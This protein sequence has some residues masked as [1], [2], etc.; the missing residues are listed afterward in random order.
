MKLKLILLNS[1]SYLINKINLIITDRFFQIINIYIVFLREDRIG[2]QVGNTDIEF[3]KAYKR[4]KVNKAKTIFIFPTPYFEVSNL[5]VREKLVQYAKSNNYKTFVLN[6]N[7]FNI[8]F[9]NLF[10]EFLKKSF[11][12]CK[13]IYFSNTDKG[14]RINNKILKKSKDHKFLCERMGISPNRYIC[15]TSR[16]QNYLT[17]RYPNRNWL[18][19]NCRNSNI[20]NLEKLSKFFVSELGYDVVRIGSNPIKKISW[21]CKTKPMI[22]DYSFSKYN[23]PKND[24]ELIS[25]CSLFINNGGGPVSAAVAARRDIVTINHIPIRLNSGFGWWFW[26]P[27]LLKYKNKNNFLSFRH[28]EEINLSRTNKELDYIKLGI[29]V[30]E[31]NDEDILN[32]VKDYFRIKKGLINIEE[33]KILARYRKIRKETAHLYCEQNLRNFKDIISP[34]FLL[35]Y[36]ELLD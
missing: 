11:E 19:H 14:K 20:D 18:Y 15:I 34:T 1:V 12:S 8:F 35:K 33:K 9:S 5:Y 22:L 16:D 13:N 23:S 26:I 25:G 7:F 24:I 10:H 28:I 3:Y 32:A 30:I 31:N 21:G 29:E 4:E 2:H 36:P 17:K 6:Y 27:K